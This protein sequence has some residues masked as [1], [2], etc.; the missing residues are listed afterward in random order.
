M[1]G[2]GKIHATFCFKRLSLAVKHGT[3]SAYNSGCRCR[4]CKDALSAYHS[5][6]N[7]WLKVK[8]RTIFSRFSL[9]DAYTSFTVHYPGKIRFLYFIHTYKHGSGVKTTT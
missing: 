7:P 1:L 6:I 8:L 3:K 5:D 2:T 4:P 9:V